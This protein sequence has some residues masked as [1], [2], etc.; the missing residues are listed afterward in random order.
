[1]KR[2]PVD[3]EVIGR[4]QDLIGFFNTVP[5]TRIVQDVEYLI[6]RYCAVQRVTMDCL[7]QVH[8]NHRE[9]LQRIFQGKYRAKT[10]QYRQV[11][12]RD[13]VPLTRFMLAHS[14]FDSVDKCIVNI[15]GLRWGRNGLRWFV[16]W[17]LPLGNTCS[18]RHFLAPFDSEI[19][20]NLFVWWPAMLTI[21]TWYTY[22]E[23]RNT[24][25]FL[26]G[27]DLQFY[28]NPI[29]LEEVGSDSL[30]GFC[31]DWQHRTITFQQP[32]T[33][34][35]LRGA[36][37]AGAKRHSIAGFHARAL[38]ISRFVRPRHLI[39]E[40]IADLVLQYLWKGFTLNDFIP[41]LT[42]LGKRFQIPSLAHTVASA[43]A[44]H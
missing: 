31:V 37:S 18:I 28:S 12:I 42:T 32:A 14:F 30:L 33:L 4:Q 13:L 9:R 21:D 35:K 43:V 11:C 5:H 2:T 26:F 7:L 29:L 20:F 27:T 8:Q 10:R 1:M 24:R 41:L 25:A 39:S 16:P 6:H 19:L 40:Q 34:S 17:L 15:W 22:Q 38:L 36:R 44:S 3:Q 23:P